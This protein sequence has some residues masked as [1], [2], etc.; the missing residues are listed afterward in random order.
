[1]APFRRAMPAVECNRKKGLGGT[2]SGTR[3]ASAR[4]SG[5]RTRNK[6]VS[7]KKVIAARRKKGRHTIA[8]ASIRKANG[9]K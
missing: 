9:K 1:M 7:G 3:R 2:L 5:W 6:S 4:T 8:P